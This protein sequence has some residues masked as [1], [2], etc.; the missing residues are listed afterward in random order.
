MNRIA[1]LRTL[2]DGLTGLPADNINDILADYSAYF[3]E[4]HGAGRSEE[5]V[6]TAL[7]DPRRLARELRVETGLRRW[8]NHRSVRNSTT[9]L[10]ALGGLA[11]VD[12]LLLLPLMF[13][14][15]LV[16]LVSGLVM[17][18]LGVIGI[19][20]LLSLFK[21]VHFASLTTIVL[22]A[23]AGIALIAASAGIGGILLLALNGIVRKLGGYA[24]LHYRLLKPEEHSV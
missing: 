23:L 1:F 12:I 3:D 11:A 21:V 19:G 22:R 17:F 13:A 4:A 24:R 18:I 20:L 9:A 2:R 8:E 5:D 15:G 6:A 16:L 7:G 14:V 10:L